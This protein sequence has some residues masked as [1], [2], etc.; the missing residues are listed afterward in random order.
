MISW[1]V[2]RPSGN[3]QRLPTAYPTLY[4]PIASSPTTDLSFAS[5][6]PLQDDH[7]N[8]SQVTFTSPLQNAEDISILLD[9]GPPPPPPPPKDEPRRIEVDDHPFVE[10]NVVDVPAVVSEKEQTTYSFQDPVEVAPREST[11]PPSVFKDASITPHGSPTLP[12]YEEEADIYRYLSRSPPMYKDDEDV[13]EDVYDNI[14]PLRS[15]RSFANEAIR[16]RSYS[17]E[18]IEPVSPLRLNKH[19]FADELYKDFSPLEANPIYDEDLFEDEPLM[20]M[21]AYYEDDDLSPLPQALYSSY[22]SSPL[23]WRTN[24]TSGLTMST[25][26]TNIS[27][28]SRP[29]DDMYSVMSTK[30]RSNNSCKDYE[31]SVDY[32]D[33]FEKIQHE[34]DISDSRPNDDML[35]QAGK[36]PIFDSDG[37]GRPFSSIYSGDTAIGE[38]Q[39]VIFVRHFFCGVS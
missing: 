7:A 38:Q 3:I 11:P 25:I 33:Y 2:D 29:S 17:S 4:S 30:A 18:D 8:D 32:E 35:A 9:V 39:M 22:N 34:I 26:A 14:S 28:Q 15:T 23:S 36:I 31:C 10:N 12:V 13:Y 37:K 21:S 16:P 6:W 1:P 5:R 27:Q 19:K 24:R 20:S